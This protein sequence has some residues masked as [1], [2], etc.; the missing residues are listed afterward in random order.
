[1]SFFLKSKFQG[2]EEELYLMDLTKVFMVYMECS[3]KSKNVNLKNNSDDVFMSKNGFKTF[4]RRFITAYSDDIYN[5]F[6]EDL[7]EPVT[8]VEHRNR[9]YKTY[10]NMISKLEE[11]F[12]EGVR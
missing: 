7:G 9:D 1:M 8:V 10:E 12:G 4:L 6:L 5:A 11:E 3:H 2:S